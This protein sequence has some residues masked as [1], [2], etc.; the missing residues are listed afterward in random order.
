[1]LSIVEDSPAVHVVS[2]RTFTFH[3][4][5]TSTLA[6]SIAEEAALQYVEDIVPVPSSCAAAARLQ[7]KMFAECWRHPM[8][9]AQ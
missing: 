7:Q 3:F 2:A 5:T 1:M 9:E 4:K 8:Q 6:Y